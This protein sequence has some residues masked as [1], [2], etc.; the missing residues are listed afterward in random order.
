M[1]KVRALIIGVRKYTAIRANNLEFCKNDIYAMRQAFIQGLNVDP[2]DIILCGISDTV[3]IA[4][5]YVE[6][7]WFIHPGVD[8]F[9]C[10][11]HLHY[12]N[13]CG[14]RC[15]FYHGNEGI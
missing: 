13:I 6:S 10:P 4:E 14:E 8:L 3:T 11:E 12:C 2:S 15:I 5:L 7:Q 9:G 1:A